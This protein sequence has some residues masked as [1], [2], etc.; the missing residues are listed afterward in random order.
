MVVHCDTL[1]L[2][3]RNE[4][5]LEH[6][7]MLL[8]HGL[9][10]TV[11]DRGENLEELRDPVMLLRLVD[12]LVEDLQG[13]RARERE[14]GRERAREMSKQA[15]ERE[16]ERVCVCVCAYLC[17]CERER[18]RSHRRTLLIDLRMCARRFVNFP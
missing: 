9:R 4:A 6:R 3:Q 10:E 8:L 1:E 7:F 18:K 14:R 15:S 17:V 13:E 5:S 2:V 12:V 11:N 16:R